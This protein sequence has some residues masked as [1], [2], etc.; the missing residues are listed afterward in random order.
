MKPFFI[1]GS[2]TNVGK[3]LVTQALAWQ[4]LQAG[5][6][7]AALKPVASGFD[8]EQ[9][10]DSDTGRLLAA[11]GEKVSEDS[12]ARVTRWRFR[13]PLSPDMAAEDEGRRIDFD[14][15]VRACQPIGDPD[16]LLIEGVGGV[17]V[18]LDACHTVLDWM[19]RLG[20]PV[21]LVGGSYLGAISHTLSAAECIVS[22]GLELRAVIVS[23]SERSPVPL[24]RLEA[25]LK[26]FLPAS[27]H[28]RSIAR[29]ASG[30]ESY[31]HVQDLTDMM[32]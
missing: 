23:E 20:Y 21:L 18:P 24:A 30:L 22:G 11:L 4:L 3:T 15:L 1:T 10:E 17:V 5:H 26:R 31:L 14:A 27:T 28:I 16:Y 29:L 7:V 19:K 8:P 2:G 32:V 9:A 13:A 6:R 25:V 12:V